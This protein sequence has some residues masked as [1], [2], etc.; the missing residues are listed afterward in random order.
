MLKINFRTA[1][2]SDNIKTELLRLT[3]GGNG[4]FGKYKF[5]FNDEVK[6]Y[7]YLVFFDDINDEFLTHLPKYKTIFIAAECTSIKKYNNK[8]LSQFGNVITT[9]DRIKHRSKY[10]R[11]PGHAWFTKKSYD[12]L[13][14]I[15]KIEKTKDICIIVSN[16]KITQGH[17]D[18]LNF[19]IRL[20]Q[21]LGDRVDLF[22]RGFNEIEDKWDILSNYKYSIAIENYCENHWITEKLGDCFIAHTFPFYMGAPNVC[23]YYSA[24]SYETI[25]IY[26]YPNSLKKIEKILNDDCHYKNNL[27]NILSAKEKYLKNHFFIPMICNFIDSNFIENKNFEIDKSKLSI[28]K[29]LKAYSNI[30]KKIY[31]RYG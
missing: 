21:D 23:D 29:P 14:N 3:E 5:Y 15:K 31:H 12:E 4:K 18:R 24:S 8:F 27:F 28:I 30:F 10:L 20:K 2:Y 19:C 13:L 7:D 22:G 1:N 26:D 9:Q 11:S 6:D 17:R 25:D 16:K